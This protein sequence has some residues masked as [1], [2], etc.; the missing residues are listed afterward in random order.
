[1]KIDT[2]HLESLL[3]RVTPGG[4]FVKNDAGYNWFD[5]NIEGPSE[6]LIAMANEDDAELIALAPTLA[7]RV[8]AAESTMREAIDLIS[9]LHDQ[10]AR[11]KL[12]QLL[13]EWDKSQ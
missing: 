10:K 13:S 2:K 1:M 8:I 11:F 12:E 3:E 4:W 9:H 6:N 7:R 5:S